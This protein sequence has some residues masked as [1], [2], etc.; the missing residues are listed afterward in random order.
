MIC[1]SLGS[2]SSQLALSDRIG[3]PVVGWAPAAIGWAPACGWFSTNCPPQS[4]NQTQGACGCPG[5]PPRAI[6]RE[7]Y[8]ILRNSGQCRA[9]SLVEPTPPPPNAPTPP[10]TAPLLLRRRPPS[11]ENGRRAA[12]PR[13]HDRATRSW[14]GSGTLTCRRTTQIWSSMR[15]VCALFKSPRPPFPHYRGVPPPVPAPILRRRGTPPDLSAAPG[16]PRPPAPPAGPTYIG[17]WRSGC[18]RPLP[19]RSRSPAAKSPHPLPRS[20]CKN[21]NRSPVPRGP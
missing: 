19:R 18:P 7:Q 5:P 17:P 12:C 4:V 2:D 8:L 21:R 6:P 14:P 15:K 20:A 10:A 13:A 1:L 11:L 3:V 9:G 16:R